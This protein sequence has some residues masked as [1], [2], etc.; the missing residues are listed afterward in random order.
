LLTTKH[1][2]QVGQRRRQEVRWENVF[3]TMR[4]GY[5]S[6]VKSRAEQYSGR[7]NIRIRGLTLEVGEDCGTTVFSFVNEKLN[8]G[9][10]AV[11]IEAAHTLPIGADHI[12]IADLSIPLVHRRLVLIN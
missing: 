8:V 9:I 4:R 6:V 7:N 2:D 12:D 1:A 3:T 5:Q 10:F 11:D